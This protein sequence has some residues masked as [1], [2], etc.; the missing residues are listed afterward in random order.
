MLKLSFNF[1]GA[2]MKCQKSSESKALHGIG[3]VL[4]YAEDPMERLKTD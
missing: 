3:E 4:R 2:V 1:L